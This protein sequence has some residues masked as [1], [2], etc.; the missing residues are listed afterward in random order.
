MS[1]SGSVKSKE[2]ETVNSPPEKV[3][4]PTERFEIT[5]GWPVGVPDVNVKLRVLEV[6]AGVV[7]VLS[8]GIT[9]A[10]AL[11]GIKGGNRLR[12]NAGRD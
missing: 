3:G 2:I 6:P 1:P 10:N 5:G 8:S 11:S 4:V 9:Q 7:T 12:R